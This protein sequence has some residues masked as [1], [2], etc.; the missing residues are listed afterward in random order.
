MP[1]PIDV[2]TELARLTAAERVQQISDR[3]SLVAQHRVAVDIQEQQ[4]VSET[5]V[6]QAHAKS[7]EVEEEARRRTPYR[8]RRHRKDNELDAESEPGEG[9]SAVPAPGDMETVPDGSAP[10]QLDV[11]I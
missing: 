8:G 1:Q 5:Q 7:E 3:L 6:Q 4:V 2:Q 10:H 11:T 9:S